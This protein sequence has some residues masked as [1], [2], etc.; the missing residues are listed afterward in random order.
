MSN[1]DHTKQRG[2]ISCKLFNLHFV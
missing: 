2:W 1:T